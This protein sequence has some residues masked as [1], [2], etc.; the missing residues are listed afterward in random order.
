MKEAGFEGW[1]DPMPSLLVACQTC[2]GRP[3][4]TFGKKCCCDF[5]LLPKEGHVKGVKEL[6]AFPTLLTTTRKNGD[7]MQLRLDVKMVT[8]ESYRATLQAFVDGS[9]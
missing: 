6:L 7:V 8:E 9:W 3:K 4:L 2:P 5:Y 1:P